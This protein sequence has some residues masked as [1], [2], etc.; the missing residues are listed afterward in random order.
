MNES[1][2]ENIKRCSLTVQGVVQGVGF[3]P[4]V[5]GL[6]SSLGLTGF[7]GNN[8]SGVFIE[9]EGVPE[10]LASFQARLV[11]EAPPLARIEAV[12]AAEIP[13]RGEPDF[14]IVHSQSEAA[15][16]TLISPDLTT[17]DDCLRELFDP[18]DRRYRYPFT[19]CTNCGPRFTIIRD[20]PYDRPLTTMA[21]FTMC[22]ACQA[23]YDDPRNRRF[24]AQPNACPECG[25]QLEFCWSKEANSFAFHLPATPDPIRHA[26]AVIGQGGIVAVKGLGG[27]HLACDA[28]S[29]TALRTLRQRKGRVDKP[30][31][32]MAPDLTTVARFAA[33]SAEEA[34]LLTS[35]ERPIVL[36]KKRPGTLLSDLVA[37]GNPYLGVMLPYTPLHYLLLGPDPATVEHPADE[38]RQMENEASSEKNSSFIIHHSSFFILVM[39]SGNYSDE[40]IAK[41]ND[42]AVD[43]LSTLADAFLLHDRPIQAHCD[44]SV[45]RVFEGQELPLRRSRGYAPFPVKLPFEV[46]P[47]LAIG[48]ELKAT[49][50]L[51]KGRYAY[52]SQH[53]GDMENLETLHA[54]Q[55][56]V[57]H[58]QALFR[59]QP[60]ALAADLHPGYLSSRWAREQ[61]L[62]INNEQLTI[63]NEQLT[64]NN[65][66]PSNPPI[67][68]PSNLPTFHF[69]QHHH[70]HLAAVMA[71]HG[72]EGT[73]PVIGF[74]FDGTGYGLDGAIWGGEVLL[75]NYQ[76]FERLA[77]LKYVPLPG[78]DAAIKRPYRTALAHLWAAGIDW[79]DGLPPVAACLATECGVIRRQLERQL[80]TVPTSSMGRLFDAVSALAGVRQTVTYEGQAAIEFEALAA[81][82]VQA[83]YAFEVSAGEV[84]AAPIIR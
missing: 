59:I 56:A 8:S 16:N 11:S 14:T 47:V 68:Q 83:S 20:I 69:I 33:V 25:P 6:A 73:E 60:Q 1:I 35:R 7:V 76:S 13:R 38:A 78:G 39:T 81:D 19:N 70:A 79:D 53:L 52:M 2:F 9:V 72:L 82:D 34:A 32:V 12:T 55:N 36:L 45:I 3:R 80:N 54:F 43:R 84:D 21:S 57:A 65:S 10:A 29:D 64:I 74:S 41:D 23:E 26:Q 66:Q 77:H 61:E 28:A 42:E 44:D 27:F 46:P 40:P 37:P 15:A 4:F 50:C 31:A 17:C 58:F 63:N 75:A 30:F 5:F 67:L 49:F 51:T 71:E 62:A 24:H 48:G 22:P 18:A